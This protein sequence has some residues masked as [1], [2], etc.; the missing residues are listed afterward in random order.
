MKTKANSPQS[1][2][3]MEEARRMMDQGQYQDSLVLAL[4]ALLQELEMVTAASHTLPPVFVETVDDQLVQIRLGV[5][6]SLFT[7]LQCKNAAVAGHSLRVALTCNGLI[8]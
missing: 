7:A 1:F 6:A 4:D 5:A 8:A 3:K 2:I